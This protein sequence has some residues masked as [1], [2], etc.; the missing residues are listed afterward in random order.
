MKLRRDYKEGTKVL[1]K[2]YD[3]WRDEIEN[4]NNFRVIEG[5]VQENTA[6]NEVIIYDDKENNVY[7]V[8]CE[9]IIK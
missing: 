6:L 7:A 1:F 5:Y 4:P 9:H 2:W 8:P 3:N